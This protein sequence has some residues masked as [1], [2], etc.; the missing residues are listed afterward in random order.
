MIEWCHVCTVPRRVL[1]VPRDP[2]VHLWVLSVTF[3]SSQCL[4]VCGRCIMNN[5]FVIMFLFQGPAGPK[6]DTGSIGPPGAPVSTETITVAWC[7]SH[8][9]V[10]LYKIQAKCSCM[11]SERVF[12]PLHCAGPTRWSY[13]AP[14]HPVTQEDQ[15]LQWHAVRRS[16][17]GLWRGH[18]GH[19]RLA[20]QPK[21]GHWTHEIP[22]GHTKQPGQNMQRPAALPPRIPWW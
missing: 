2:R 7:S 22:H 21:T 19:L 13:P 16:H 15:A 10:A 1:K 4:W 8:S 12:F 6:G 11:K 3:T 20:Q 5:M 14:A 9:T 18:G 17:H